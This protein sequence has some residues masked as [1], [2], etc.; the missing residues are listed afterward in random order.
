MD[1][2]DGVDI[3]VNNF[4]GSSAPS[5]GVLALTDADWQQTFRT[6]LF[7]AVRNS[8]SGTCTPSAK[9]TK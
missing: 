4:G 9:L 1:R 6:N 3:L 8:E 2:L 7:A 5:G